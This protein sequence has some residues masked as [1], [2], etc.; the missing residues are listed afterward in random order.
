MAFLRFAVPGPK[1]GSCEVFL[2]LG[3]YLP[4]V[5][6]ITGIGHLWSQLPFLELS[7]DSD[8]HVLN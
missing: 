5:F 2:C 3:L 1:T 8:I 6:I 7:L 4:L